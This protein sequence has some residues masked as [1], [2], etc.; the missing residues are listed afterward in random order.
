M[1]RD[2]NFSYKPGHT[3]LSFMSDCTTVKTY[4]KRLV[5]CFI[6]SIHDMF[7]DVSWIQKQSLLLIL[8]KACVEN[9]T[10]EGQ[11]VCFFIPCFN[12]DKRY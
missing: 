11:N 7:S 6:S 2:V 1:F 12:L 10:E 4:A 8:I 5:L 3:Q 9:S